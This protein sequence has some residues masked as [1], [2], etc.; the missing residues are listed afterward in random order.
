MLIA[1]I[2]FM[3]LVVLITMYLTNSSF[4]NS[5]GKKEIPKSLY[6]KPS[7]LKFKTTWWSDDHVTPYFY[8]NGWQPLLS[9]DK[10]NVMNDYE[11]VAKNISYRLGNGNFEYEKKR[12]ATV[13]LCLEHNEQVWEDVKRLRK[14]KKEYDEKAYRR[15]QEALERAN[16]N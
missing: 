10:P 3:V 7:K 6:E 14:E 9:V 4:T 16:N 12:W 2:V 1:V 13:G 8:H 15:K 11:Y 5:D